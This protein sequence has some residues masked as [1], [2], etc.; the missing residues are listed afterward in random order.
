MLGNLL[1]KIFGNR[2]G[3]VVLGAAVLAF[4]FLAF[5]SSKVTCGSRTMRAGDECTTTS[6]GSST[7][8]SYEEQRA[9]DGRAR[10]IAIGIGGVL[11]A[12]GA[13][14]I[15]VRAVRPRSKPE[16]AVPGAPAAG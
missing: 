7:T 13:A 10:M 2:F 1:W 11:I 14:A 8:R 9:V 5:D 12:G 15:V 4:A 6:N 16:T 3:A